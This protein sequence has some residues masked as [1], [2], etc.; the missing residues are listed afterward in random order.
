MLNHLIKNKG[1]LH[2]RITDRIKLDPFTLSETEEFLKMKNIV[3]DRYQN[4]LLFMAFGGIPF[5]LD[6][7]KPGKSATQN[8]NDLSFLVNAPFRL[9]YKNLFASNPFVIDKSYAEIL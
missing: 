5:Y 4:M 1:G 9:E 7:I 8:I 2:N 3:Y 6:L